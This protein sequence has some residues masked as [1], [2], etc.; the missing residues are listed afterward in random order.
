MS[1][2]GESGRSRQLRDKAQE[3]KAAAEKSTDPQER[4]RLQDKARRLQEQSEMEGRMMDDPG[5]DLR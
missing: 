1:V 3:M 5:M 4:T 2:A